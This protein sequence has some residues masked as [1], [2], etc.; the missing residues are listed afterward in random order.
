GS[1]TSSRSRS[2]SSSY[3]WP[4]A[5][6]V[7]RR[8]APDHRPARAP[9]GAVDPV[10]RSFAGL[11]RPSPWGSLPWDYPGLVRIL[12]PGSGGLAHALVRGRN[13]TGAGADYHLGD[14]RPAYGVPP[15]P[16]PED[17]DE[18]DEI[19]EAVDER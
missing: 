3:G 2:P 12:G 14:S 6:R 8:G 1:G 4:P 9:A 13:H 15:R 7:A 18:Q 16:E 19:T 10:A 5:G 17:A 11:S